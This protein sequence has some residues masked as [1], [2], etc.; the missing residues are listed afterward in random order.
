MP[1]LTVILTDTPAG[2]YSCTVETLE[3][4]YVVLEETH[5]RGSD[6]VSSRTVHDPGTHHGLM[7]D[8]LRSMQPVTAQL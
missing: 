2:D 3:G 1:S 6:V 7:A 5:H 8:L 4:G